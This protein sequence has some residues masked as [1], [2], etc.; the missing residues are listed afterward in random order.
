MDPNVNSPMENKSYTLNL[1]LSKST[2]IKLRNA[3]TSKLRC[4]VLMDKGIFN[5]F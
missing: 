2:F 1:K 4:I 3:L 5:F